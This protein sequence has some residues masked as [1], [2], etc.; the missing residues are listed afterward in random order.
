MTVYKVSVKGEPVTQGSMKGFYIGGHVVMVHQKEKALLS[1]REAI[2]RAFRDTVARPPP[3][4]PDHTP[5][6]V[7]IIAYLKKPKSAP[8]NREY[9]SVKGKDVDKI[10]RAVLDGMTGTVYKDDSQVVFTLAGKCYANSN[11]EEHTDIYALDV[12][13][14]LSFIP[15]N[16]VF[17]SMRGGN[18]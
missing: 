9:P 10:T 7:C 2:A 1:Y 18:A 3:Y 4:F 11:E 16:A 12:A 8:K 6:V 15:V 5:V 14:F 13:T 17:E